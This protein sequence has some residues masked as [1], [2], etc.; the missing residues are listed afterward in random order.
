MG[1]EKLLSARYWLRLWDRNIDSFLAAATKVVVILAAYFIV[2]F[3]LFKFIG[4]IIDSVLS[5]V[6]Q[7]VL[8]ARQERVRALQSLLGSSV[9]FVLGF[10]AAVMILQTVGLN[11]VPLITTASVAGLAVG[12]G[13]QKLVRDVIAGVFALV[14]DHY[15]VGDYVTIGAVSGVVEEFGMRT[16]RIRDRTGKL[17]IIS[18]GDIAQVCNHSRG[19]FVVVQ[20]VVVPASTDLEQAKQVLDEVGAAVTSELAS[21]VTQPFRCE[22]VV[23]IGGASATVRLVGGA[24]P[25]FEQDVRMALNERIRAAFAAGD[26]SL[27]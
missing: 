3:L 17:F 27:A 24:Q 15:G 12:F 2:R 5:R 22:G 1:F 8:Q 16:T 9:G 25:Q 20:D 14:E 18:N 21:V 6:S 10:I 11:I 26:L 7:E 4:R 13:A 23:Q 19:V